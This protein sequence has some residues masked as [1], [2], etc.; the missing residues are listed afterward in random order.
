MTETENPLPCPWCGGGTETQSEMVQS[1]N[2]L[3]FV[4]CRMCCAQGPMVSTREAAVPDWNTVAR[5][6]AT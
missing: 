1:G 3:Y 4:A 2:T 6:F 5:R